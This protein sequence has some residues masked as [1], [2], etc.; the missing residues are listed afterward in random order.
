MSDEYPEIPDYIKNLVESG[1]RIEEIRIDSEG[2]WYHEGEPFTN[3]RI[4]DFFNRSVDVT[5]DGE[6]VIHYD[7][8]VYPIVVEDTP[9]FVTGVRVEGFSFFEKI[10]ITLTTGEEEE[11]DETTLYYSRPDG[12]YCRVQDGR[13]PAK[14]KRSPSFQLLERLQETDDTYYISIKGNKVVL[15]E[16]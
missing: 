14:F 16:K 6:Y 12:L 4:I 7:D 9:V 8:Y 1:E 10:Y 2:N 5:A 15:E 11:L 3:Q 13:L